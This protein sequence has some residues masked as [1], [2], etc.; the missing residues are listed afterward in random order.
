MGPERKRPFLAFMNCCAPFLCDLF[1]VDPL[2]YYTNLEVMADIQLKGIAW[3]LE[4]L[5]E[6]EVPRAVFLD[7]ATVYEAIAFDLPIQYHPGSAPWGG[8]WIRDICEVDSLPPPNRMWGNLLKLSDKI[9]SLARLWKPA[10]LASVH[11]H[12][13]HG[14]PIVHRTG[15]VRLVSTIRSGSA[16]YWLLHPGFPAFEAREVAVRRT[17]SLDESFAGAKAK[18]VIPCLDQRRYLR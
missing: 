2:E 4:N 12:L 17:R 14:G 10:G 7:Q 9:R 15:P 13:H 1:G 8:H 16:G 18:P 5:D 11:L 3:R 6:D